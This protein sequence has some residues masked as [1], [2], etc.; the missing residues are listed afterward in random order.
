[1]RAQGA[2]VAEASFSSVNDFVHAPYSIVLGE[3]G[4]HR[5]STRW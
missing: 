4:V 1:M 2:Q 5:I 3:D